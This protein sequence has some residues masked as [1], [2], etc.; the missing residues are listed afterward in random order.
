MDLPEWQRTRERS[1]VFPDQ[2]GMLRHLLFGLS[3]LDAVTFATVAGIIAFAAFAAS[4]VPARQ[5]VRLDP[6]QALRYE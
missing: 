5:A 3:P 4:C 6:V 1:D 2:G